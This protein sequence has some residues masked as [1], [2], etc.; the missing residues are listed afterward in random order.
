MARLITR[1]G[2]VPSGIARAQ[3]AS[4]EAPHQ[5]APFSE[6][7]D[8]PPESPPERAS[9]EEVPI[10]QQLAELEARA[11]AQVAAAQAEA[12]RWRD[13]A[14]ATEAASQARGF[15]AGYAEG[16]TEGRTVGE[17]AIK[18]ELQTLV[19]HLAGLAQQAHAETEAT[20]QAAQ[21]ALAALSI[22]IA[23][24]V[25]GEALRLDE[26]LLA[27]RITA[28][29]A[30][31]TESL[32]TTVR[33]HPMDLVGLQPLW[34]A[35][36]PRLVGDANL[37]LGDCLITTRTQYFDGRLEA[38]FGLVK[39]AFATLPA[40]EGLIESYFAPRSQNESLQAGVLPEN[41]MTP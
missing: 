22:E 26:G 20:L 27:R 19:D 40:R 30:Q 29:C 41:E 10:A 21:S 14:L 13:H 9:V 37:A 17:T 32:G 38:L 35:D 1:S 33:V 11:A 6:L 25:V 2:W 28:L 24:A 34:P 4:G 3:P 5:W 36:Q 15:A 7:A 31:M 39:D 23:R 18:A 8:V 16:I 12:E